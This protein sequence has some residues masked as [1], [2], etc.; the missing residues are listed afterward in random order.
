MSAASSPPPPKV[1]M[2]QVVT[3]VLITAMVIGLVMAI[4]LLRGARVSDEGLNHYVPLGYQRQVLSMLERPETETQPRQEGPLQYQ[5]SQAGGDAFQPEWGSLNFEDSAANPGQRKFFELSKRL[6]NDIEMFNETGDGFFQVGRGGGVIIAP[7]FHNFALPYPL[8]NPLRY[9]IAM[10]GE[11]L[12]SLVGEKLYFGF[13]PLDP[14]HSA[15]ATEIQ[16]IPRSSWAGLSPASPP[17]QYR[18]PA[19]ELRGKDGIIVR[20]AM[21]GDFVQMEIIDTVETAIFLN[22]E[23]INRSGSDAVK[24]FL[25]RAETMPPEILRHPNAAPLLD[26]DRLRIVFQ[27]NGDVVALRY[28]RYSGG[29]VTRTWMENGRPV[30][31]VDPELE[32]ELPYVGQLHRA[33]N[34]YAENH[35]NPATLGQPNFRLTIDRDLNRSISNVFFP[36]V[37]NFDARLASLPNTLMEPAC[38]AVVDATTGDVLALPSYP[39]AEDLE[40]LRSRA[41]NKSLPGLSDAK[42]RRLAYNQ[43]LLTVPIGSTTKPLLASAIWETYPELRRLVVNESGSSRSSLYGYRFFKPYSTVAR[44]PV[45]PTRFLQVSSN[46]YTI[47]LA[48]LTLAK[49][50]RLD[51]KG[52]PIFPGGRADFSEFLSGDLI[53]GGLY[54]PRELPAFP[55]LAECWDVSLVRGLGAGSAADWNR[56]L[57]EPVFQ[58]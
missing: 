21:T 13:A 14:G 46:D 53:K 41:R 26:G 47:N 7:Y 24:R 11:N 30:T 56:G 40:L 6:Q 51:S 52:N 27:E 23:R 54:R 5:P 28:G 10:A 58:Q 55:K 50:V 31:E 9:T 38:V 22:G 25:K 2:K 19:M 4:L 49:Q 15:S 8:P 34:R 57:L 3:G 33:M 36:Y 29:L 12:P 43:N 37:R 44:G 17:H 45:D 35:P 48:M 1:R 20:L 16:S 32:K 18:G 39:A 42:L